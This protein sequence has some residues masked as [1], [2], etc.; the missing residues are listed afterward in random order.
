MVAS[1][2]ESVE[3][4]VGAY[5]LPMPTP[6]YTY[7]FSLGSGNPQPAL[8]Q[9]I[10]W[11]D[12]MGSSRRHH[13]AACSAGSRKH[14]LRS[15]MQQQKQACISAQAAQESAARIGTGDRVAR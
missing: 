11:Q 13:L 12:S 15:V 1:G 10:T 5:A 7:V 8:V 14:A 4:A 6:G 2:E 9:S 3:I